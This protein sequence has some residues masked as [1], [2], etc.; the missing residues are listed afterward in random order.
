[1]SG[2]IEP[3]L[4]LCNL[5]KAILLVKNIKIPLMTF[6]PHNQES[7][8]FVLVVLAFHYKNPLISPVV[9][10]ELFVQPNHQDIEPAFEKRSKA[11]GLL[12]DKARLVVMLQEISFMLMQEPRG[13]SFQIHS[14]SEV[15][16]E[17]EKQ[18]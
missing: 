17:G 15:Q 9:L 16:M 8:R 3:I 18:M 1:M 4:K 7:V 10:Q 13:S 6:L 2:F 14:S 5:R 11:N 12:S